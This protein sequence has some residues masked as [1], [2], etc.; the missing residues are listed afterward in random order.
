MY[1]PRPAWHQRANTVFPVLFHGGQ[2]I[3]CGVHVARRRV[4]DAAREAL[5]QPVAAIAPAR[6][7]SG[8]GG[9][10]QAGQVRLGQVRLE[11][12]RASCRERVFL[13]V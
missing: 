5:A 10:T 8:W 11:I 2:K 9:P 3:V 7:G 4:G 12:G 1:A 6:R 13:S